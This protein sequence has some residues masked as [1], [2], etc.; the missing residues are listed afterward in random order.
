MRTDLLDK[1]CKQAKTLL[2][3]N[4][5]RLVNIINLGVSDAIH[6]RENFDV[7]EYRIHEEVILKFLGNDEAIELYSFSIRKNN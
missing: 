2:G 1:Y 7:G 5:D 6:V 4:P 3:E